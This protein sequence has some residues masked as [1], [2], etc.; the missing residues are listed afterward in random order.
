MTNAL[1]KKFAS[2]V[3]IVALYAES[4]NLTK[5]HTT[6]RIAPAMTGAIADKLM[7]M[8]DIVALID[9]AEAKPNGPN[10]YRTRV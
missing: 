2:H 6:L 1:S 7:T 9:A 8:E 4:Y 5:V 10:T 3:H